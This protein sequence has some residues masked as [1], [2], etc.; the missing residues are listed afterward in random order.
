MT[1]VFSD[2]TS[3]R[4]IFDA[5]LPIQGIFDDVIFDTALTEAV[6]THVLLPAFV[7]STD[8]ITAL[9]SS[10]ETIVVK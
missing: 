4:G 5:N 3:D 2:S 8:T 6:V 10:K 7:H 1:K 9:V